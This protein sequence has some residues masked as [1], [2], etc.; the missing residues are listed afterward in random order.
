MIARQ[1]KM[2]LQVSY[3]KTGVLKLETRLDGKT[4]IDL[5]PNGLFCRFGPGHYDQLRFRRHFYHEIAHCYLSQLLNLQNPVCHT[6]NLTCMQEI[7]VASL[8]KVIWGKEISLDIFLDGAESQSMMTT[9]YLAYIQIFTKLLSQQVIQKI[10]KDSEKLLNSVGIMIHNNPRYEFQIEI[11]C[12]KQLKLPEKFTFDL[13][14]F[15]VDATN[16]F[17]YLRT[18]RCPHLPIMGAVFKSSWSALS[19]GAF[20]ADLLEY[21]VIQ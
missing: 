8:M 15:A 3:D 17:V 11:D 16:Y 21:Q 12:V 7:L 14:K 20:Y 10:Q 18:E 2:T 19:S 6:K 13:E 5:I 1:R 4:R 9:F